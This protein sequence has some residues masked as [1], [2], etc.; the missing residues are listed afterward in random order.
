[1]KQRLRVEEA[2]SYVLSLDL[3]LLL[4]QSLIVRHHLSLCALPVDHVRTLQRNNSSS[5]GTKA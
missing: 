5:E 1:M 2:F 4:V 3:V